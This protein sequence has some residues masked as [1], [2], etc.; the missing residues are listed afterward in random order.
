MKRSEFIR[1]LNAQGCEL[2]REGGRHSWWQNP[3]QNRRF[4]IPR[5]SEISD[6][7]ANKI[8]KDLG[9]KPVK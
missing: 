9:V 4:A 1:Y 2:L 3:L 6:I 8:C 5:H 7:L